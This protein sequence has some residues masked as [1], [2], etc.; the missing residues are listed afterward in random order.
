M[1]PEWFAKVDDRTGTLINATIVMLVA[2]TVVAF[3]TKLEILVN[4]LSISTLFIFMLRA[5][6]AGVLF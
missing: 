6:P 1:I 5:S 3:F 4:L 2:T